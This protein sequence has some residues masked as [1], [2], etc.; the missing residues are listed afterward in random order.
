MRKNIVLIIVGICL[1]GISV[2]MVFVLANKK[3]DVVIVA[4]KQ[5]AQVKKQT[6][7]PV[8]AFITPHHLV[9]DDLIEDI[10][11]KTFQQ[12]KNSDIDKIILISPNHFNVK[13]GNII[14]DNELLLN[15]LGVNSLLDKKLIYADSSVFA[16]EHGI[17]NILPFI[18]KYFPDMPV[19]SMMIRAGTNKNEI[20]KLAYELSKDEGFANTLFILS[21][22]FSH[23]LTPQ[24]SDMHDKVTIDTVEHFDFDNVY[25]LDTD[26][27]EGLYLLMKVS[28]FKDYNKFNFVDGSN[29]SKEYNNFF[30][31]DNTSYVTGQFV[32]ESDDEIVDLGRVVSL[33]F[34]GDVM[35]DRTVRQNIDRLGA[36][37][38]TKDIKRIFWAQD[39]NMANLEGPVTN[40][41]SVSNVSQDNPNHFKF[42]FDPIQTKD[43]LDFNRVN[44][45]SI[46][47]NHI[48]NFGAEGVAQTEEF[49]QQNNVFYV[50]VP[51]EDAKNIVYKDING[52]KIAFVPYND[53]APPSI[54]KTLD[55]IKEAKQN[56]DI[57]I[58][59]THWGQEYNKKMTN[60]QRE[61]AHQ[62]ID[63]GAKVVI[64]AHPHVIE[65]IETYRE[66]V[67]FYSL[68]N[69]V[70]DQ[71]FDEDVK[72]RLLVHMLIDNNNKLQFVLTLLYT[73][74]YGKL[75]L[76]DEVRRK[77]ILQEI[78]TNSAV[79]EKLKEKII[80]GK[81]EIK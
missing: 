62:F 45:V 49:L 53:F 20:E 39:V 30:I 36:E 73:R 76:A 3:E 79:D 42:T 35:L 72:E 81:F 75:G 6:Q 14:V 54:E 38:F 51:R 24:L 70:F 60:L 23:E 10:F 8:I 31:G 44:A 64:G 34:G 32:A 33:S 22:D 11:N 25:N 67:I 58:I 55:S 19:L 4:K 46:G 1:I 80:E 65:P 16:K 12:N 47:N 18:N 29:S 78:A 74:S 43:F 15:D 2:A 13:G 63:A 40:N 57:V 52:K 21:S 48:L 9:A 61:Q 5:I 26:C 27:V 71:F 17:Q 41:P 68:G 37:Y 56:S 28:Q 77:K 59:F 69:F 66:G 7:M 50:G